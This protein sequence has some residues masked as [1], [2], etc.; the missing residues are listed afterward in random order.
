MS[1]ARGGV[2]PQASMRRLSASCYAFRGRILLERSGET[3]ANHAH[4]HDH[5]HTD[6]DDVAA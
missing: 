4:Q 5:P 1:L 2:R 6:L 3:G